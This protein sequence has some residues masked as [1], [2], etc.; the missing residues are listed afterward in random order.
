MTSGKWDGKRKFA[1]IFLSLLV[2][3]LTACGGATAPAGSAESQDKAATSESKGG[4]ATS[5]EVPD[6]VT[7]GVQTLITPEL[8][9]RTENL[10]EKYLGTKVNLVQFDSGADVN[11]AFASGS[12]DFAS[13]GT[14][15]ASIGISKDMGYKVIWYHDVI[16]SAESLAVTK[17]SGIESVKDL[18]GKKVATPFASTAHYSLQNAMAQEGV[19]PSDVELL[20]MQP[21]DIFAAWTRGD[22]DAAYV[23]NPVLAELVKAGG[24]LVIGGEE[25]SAKGIVTADLAVVSKTFADK[26]PDV[27]TNY[28][29]AQIYAVDLYNSDKDKAVSEMAETASISKEDCM[30]QTEG[31]IYPTGEDQ[32]GPDYFGLADGM[33]HPVTVDILKSA[34]DFLKEQGSI[35]SVPELSV[36]VDSV[37]G[38]YIEAA[39]K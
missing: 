14:S 39:L 21:D 5:S 16:G 6:V 23:W 13:I 27:V 34:A 12:L 36:F 10:Y 26:Y 38:S 30:G 2:M 3:G 28:V 29:K 7:I 17:D 4:E 15:P 22:I 9:V 37:D 8:L 32:A 18:V 11:R 33:D 35:D 31:F 1:A 19:S 24:K 25:L 20:D